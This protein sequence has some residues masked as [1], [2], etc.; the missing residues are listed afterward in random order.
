MSGRVQALLGVLLLVLFG[1][2]LMSATEWV[3]EEVYARPKGE[4][5]TNNLYPAQ[6]I[7][8]KLGATVV[9]RQALDALPPA[10][11]TLV[12]TSH[13]WD[14]FED[15]TAQLRKWIE[16]GGHLVVHGAMVDSD[17]I[18]KWL[19][20]VA[21]DRARPA[22]PPANEKKQDAT[23]RK[24]QERCRD[25]RTTG[26]SAEATSTLRLCH[27]FARSFA[28]YGP[29]DATAPTQWALSDADGAE[30]LRVGFGKGSVTVLGPWASFL[31]RNVLDADNAEALAAALQLK[32]GSV[33]G[34][35]PRNRASLC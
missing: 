32:G 33:T 16:Q 22:S 11:A 15:R 34:S 2:W 20:L 21:L 29:R 14:M 28:H 30:L 1:A 18:N 7:L 8:R 23:P 25:L 10:G 26:A 19:P 3:D 35:S 27:S 5:A 6:Q 13:E 31:D 12:L 9:R 4:A 17:T 24:K